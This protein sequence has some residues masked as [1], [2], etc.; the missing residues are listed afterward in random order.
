MI[1][2]DPFIL[3]STV[4]SPDHIHDT[5]G[6][7]SASIT[8]QCTGGEYECEHTAMVTLEAR[9]D[10][11]NT[12]LNCVVYSLDPDEMLLGD[13]ATLIVIGKERVIMLFYIPSLCNG[14]RCVY[15]CIV[16]GNIYYML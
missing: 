7:I 9:M 1:L 11:N 5:Y 6:I 13:P 3:R 15:Q 12:E 16:M 4:T 10:T 2:N 14:I 8:H